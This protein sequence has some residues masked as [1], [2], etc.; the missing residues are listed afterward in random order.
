MQGDPKKNGGPGSGHFTKMSKQPRPPDAG[1]AEGVPFEKWDW[2]KHDPEFYKVF[3]NYPDA[4]DPVKLHSVKWNRYQHAKAGGMRKPDYSP[5][6][7][8]WVMRKEI[9]IFTFSVVMGLF[10]IPWWWNG[11][12]RTSR[13]QSMTKN[14]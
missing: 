10:F 11:K 1:S 8:A 4:Q 7:F 5:R 13:E 14:P 12:M 6:N 3:Q 2:Q 9:G